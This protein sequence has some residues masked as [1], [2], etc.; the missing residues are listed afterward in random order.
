MAG[1]LIYNPSQELVT[2]SDSNGFF[3]VELPHTDTLVFDYEGFGVRKIVFIKDTVIQLYL[4]EIAITTLAKVQ[5]DAGNESALKSTQMSVNEYSQEEIKRI[6]VLLGE[7][8]LLKVIQLKPGV[9]INGEG[10]GGINVRGG[11]ADQNLVLF[12]DAVVYN[13]S[14]LFGFFSVF[15]A[16]VI[17]NVKVYKGDFPA[18]Y[19][20]KLSS[21]I[22]VN[23]RQPVLDSVC[24]AGGLGILAT[25]L[26]V[27]IPIVKGKS[28]I[29]VSSRRTY[30]DAYSNQINKYK[31]QR[32]AK[33]QDIPLYYFQD[34]NFKYFHKFNAKNTLSAQYF[35]SKD[36]LNLKST[37]FD[38][39][40]K[41]QNMVSSVKW[42]HLF[43]SKVLLNQSVSF[44]NY[45]YK[46]GT[47][48]PNF[49][50]EVQNKINEVCVKSQLEY[51]PTSQTNYVIGVS[52]KKY[53]MELGRLT[54]NN[55]FDEIHLTNPA[56]FYEFGTYYNYSHS[57][58]AHLTTEFGARVNYVLNGKISYQQL[59]PRASL[60]YK[61]TPKSSLKASYS[62]VHQNLH[63]IANS[64]SSLPVDYWYPTTQKIKPQ[65]ADLF[66][67]GFTQQLGKSLLFSTET[68][69]KKLSNQLNFKNNAKLYF[70]PNLENEITIGQGWAYGAEFYLEKKLG[71]YTG[72]IGYT[73]SWSKRQFDDLNNGDVFYAKNDRRHDISVVQ[74]YKLSKKVTLS[75]TW[76]YSSG[77]VT[78][79]PTGKMLVEGFDHQK[80]MYVPVYTRINNYRIPAYHRLDL[81]IT[82][83]IV[84][85]W[86][87]SDLNFSVFNTYSRK[88]TFFIAF[89]PV[90]KDSKANTLQPLKAVSV[91]LF[92]ILPSVTYNFKF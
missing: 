66:A 75:A 17:K 52:A 65:S 50:L 54:G 78:T 22:E 58:N 21:V 26:T 6:P 88:N 77:V 72:W 81:G 18:N 85:K 68:F 42:T 73:L 8:D 32:D 28:A 69:Y 60:L 9:Q 27:D 14:H 41:W 25:R 7:P 2:E 46:A 63:L 29:M 92:P 71:D 47:S 87:E 74:T 43:N 70:N 90:T 23:S 19:S 67:V 59:E 49:N 89:E 1:V 35:F 30:L 79:L 57:L 84:S 82:Y 34:F 3:Q 61:L 56:S 48:L 24:G 80:M 20:G 4:N 39:Y 5:L 40:L 31:H 83:N 86:G 15:N 37:S 36:K 64:T 33:W 62:R 10:G 55:S 51:V 12:D 44:S 38:L 11:E 53:F 76:V 16:D 45:G 13:P 91:S